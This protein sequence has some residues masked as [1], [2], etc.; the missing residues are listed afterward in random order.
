[1]KFATKFPCVKISNGKIVVEPLPYL[2]V[3]RLLVVNVNLQPN[4]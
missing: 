2:M 4:F 3:Y 1:M